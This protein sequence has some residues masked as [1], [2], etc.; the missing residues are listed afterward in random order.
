MGMAEE[1]EAEW[2]SARR[3]ICDS[4][5]ESE[6]KEKLDKHFHA[7]GMIWNLK[8]ISFHIPYHCVS[9]SINEISIR[10]PK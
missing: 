10:L 3:L 4:V 6:L 2:S 9:S 1:E 5:P 7:G 8:K